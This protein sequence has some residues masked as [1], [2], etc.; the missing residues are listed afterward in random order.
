ME[1]NV[2]LTTIILLLPVLTFIWSL[3][4]SN[5]IVC[6]SRWLSTLLWIYSSLTESDNSLWTVGESG[7]KRENNQ[8]GVLLVFYIAT[9]VA[10][11][12]QKFKKKIHIM[13]KE[14]SSPISVRKKFSLQ[15]WYQGNLGTCKKS[16]VHKTKAISTIFC[17]YWSQFGTQGSQKLEVFSELSWL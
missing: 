4:E 3:T 6:F 11:L 14:R 12:F 10:M 9:D 2:I 5:P 16:F 1:T 17:R 13:Q 8:G 15:V 7:C